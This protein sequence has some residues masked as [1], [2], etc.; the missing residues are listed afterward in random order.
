VEYKK[1]VERLVEER[2]AMYAAALEAELAERVRLA[3][4]EA[5]RKVCTLY[6]TSHYMLC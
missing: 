6:I 1:E 5:E 2:K 4:A 3:D